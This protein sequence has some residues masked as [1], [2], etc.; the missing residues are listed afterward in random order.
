MKLSHVTLLGVRGVRDVELDL[1]NPV[2]G[3]P[4]DVVVVTGPSASGK[5]RLLEAIVAAKEAMAPYGPMAPSGPWIAEGAWLAKVA[6]GFVLDSEEKTYANL[7]DR[8]VEAEATFMPQRSKREADDGLVAVLARYDHTR[9]VGKLEYF[10]ASRRL[11]QNPP[12]H[13]TTEIEQRVVRATK[14]AR[15][16]SF[17][18]R[19]LKDLASDP[20]RE[21]RFA[22]ALARLSPSCRYV[23]AEASLAIPR[24]LAS[25]RGASRAWTELSDAEADAVLFAATASAIGLDR[26]I[27]LIDRPE[28]FVD[29]ASLPRF[30]EALRTLGENN[31]L[32][33]ASSSP[34]VVEALG[35]AAVVRLEPR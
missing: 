24:V 30:V 32:V 26:S 19:F 6:L 35:L 17:V 8:R 34:A 4:H 31:Q 27:L 23:R 28:L 12:F 5:T 9:P 13:G 21:K 14:D 15:K 2:T 20:P 22:D 3:D 11:P 7:D 33:L 16:Y 10:P 25:G 1:T 18:P 29:A